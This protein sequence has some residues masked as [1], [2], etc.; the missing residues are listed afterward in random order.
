VSG[1]HRGVERENRYVELKSGHR[2][3][4]PASIGWVTF[5]KT[6]RT[7]YYQGKA[8][9]RL[10]GGGFSSNHWDV[11]TGEEY[12][13]SGVKKNGEDRQWAGKGRVHVDA[14]ARE[15][16]ERITGRRAGASR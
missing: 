3:D 8:L 16:Y 7:I 15:E 1:E 2:D 11:K 5:S 6:G 10:S 13:I 12:W 9:R 4:G 14:D